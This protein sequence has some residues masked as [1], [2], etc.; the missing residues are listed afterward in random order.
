[1]Q[2]TIAIYELDFA[3]HVAHTMLQTSNCRTSRYE[4]RQL[5]V[6]LC[7][8]AQGNQTH[9]QP[10]GNMLSFSGLNWDP[11]D[12]YPD[13]NL[14]LYDST[15]ISCAFPSGHIVFPL[16]ASPPSTIRLRHRQG[17]WRY[18]RNAV[19]QRLAEFSSLFLLSKWFNHFIQCR[20]RCKGM[21]LWQNRVPP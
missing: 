8:Q 4:A 15:A 20:H 7:L 1:M 14:H 11:L 5:T 21:L 6:G 12:L 3:D 10:L 17:K 9:K 13:K 18:L 16:Y 19:L 2:L